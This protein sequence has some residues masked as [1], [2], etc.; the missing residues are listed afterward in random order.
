MPPV[1]PGGFST[2]DHQGN[3]K[4]SSR[5][6]IVLGLLGFVFFFP[7]LLQFYFPIVSS[8]EYFSGPMLDILEFT[9][10]QGTK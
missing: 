6:F 5:S 10:D 7:S 1:L 8:F 3:P 4:F 9:P 2:L